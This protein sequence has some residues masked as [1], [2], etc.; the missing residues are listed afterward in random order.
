[1]NKK[2]AI[3]KYLGET[4]ENLIHG[5]QYQA[6]FVEYWE[7]ERNNLH[8]LDESGEINYWYE[9][10]D[11][12]IIEDKDSLLNLNEATVKCLTHRFE[13]DFTSC[14]EYGKE[15]KAI[16]R[17]GDEYLIYTG[18]LNYFF[19][20]GNFEVVD[21]SQDVLKDEIYCR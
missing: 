1:M 21:D 14:L 5:K 11:F 6:Y 12:E 2:P 7:T 17:V 20:A 9:L 10:E 13:D 3:V 19:N 8:V 16:G 15:Y 18:S 4:N